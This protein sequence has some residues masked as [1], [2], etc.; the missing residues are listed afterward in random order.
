MT[1]SATKRGN[2]D[3]TF[4]LRKNIQRFRVHFIKWYSLLKLYFDELYG[5]IKNTIEF[6]GAL[7]LCVAHTKFDGL[8]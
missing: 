4:Y 5:L 2:S 1:L 7:A 8:I 3:L 6:M